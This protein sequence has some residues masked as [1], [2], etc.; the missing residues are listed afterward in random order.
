MYLHQRKT[1]FSSIHLH[2]NRNAS[3]PRRRV[4]SLLDWSS[5]DLAAS[6]SRRLSHRYRFRNDR[7]IPL[8]GQPDQIRERISALSGRSF[9]IKITGWLSP[10]CCQPPT[11]C[12]DWPI[13][14]RRWH[15]GECDRKLSSGCQPMVNSSP[16]YTAVRRQCVRN[17]V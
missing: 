2:R 8:S 15:R 11:G 14:D 7:I 4:A 16:A 13:A 9:L 1:H 3:L 6:F 10:R 5:D 17:V 12:C